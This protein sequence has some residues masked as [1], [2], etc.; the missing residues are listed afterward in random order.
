MAPQKAVPAVLVRGDPYAGLT[1]LERDF[2]AN[3]T[4]PFLGNVRKSG[5]EA[6]LAA[7]ERGEPEFQDCTLTWVGTYLMKREPVK[8]AIEAILGPELPTDEA[9]LGGIARIASA[10]VCRIFSECFTEH[11]DYKEKHEGDKVICTRTITQRFD[12]E[13]MKASGLGFMLKSYKP[14]KLGPQFELHSATWA[15]ELLGKW[16]GLFQDK[17]NVTTDIDFAKLSIEQ[18][19][20][21]RDGKANQ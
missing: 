6:G 15:L 21:I 3:Y 5:V 17:L 8:M 18:L 9:I 14:T 11:V 13:K 10:D 16:K 20:A 4:G 1:Q 2:V 19:K 7:K 12:I